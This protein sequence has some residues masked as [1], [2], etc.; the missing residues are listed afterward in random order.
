M[1]KSRSIVWITPEN[2]V[3]PTLSPTQRRNKRRPDL[4]NRR[5]AA[6]RRAEME[7]PRGMFHRCGFFGSPAGVMADAGR[8]QIT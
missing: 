7:E 4:A 2:T 8:V 3:P 5:E 6:A 1:L